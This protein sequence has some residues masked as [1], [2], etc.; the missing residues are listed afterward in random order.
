MTLSLL[1][2]PNTDFLRLLFQCIQLFSWNIQ[3]LLSIKWA[4][5]HSYTQ[6]LYFFQHLFP[7]THCFSPNTHT[8]WKFSIYVPVFKTLS[9]K[10]LKLTA[11][12]FIFIFAYMY[13]LQ[14]CT[15]LHLSNTNS[16]VFDL[17]IFWLIFLIASYN[18]SNICCKL[19]EITTFLHIKG[20]ASSSLIT[21]F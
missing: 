14:S 1:V 2:L 11:L 8:S 12:I 10:I 4:E 19:F 16:L 9:A 6:L 13:N 17:L 3:F 15:L 7:A 20:D 18:L 5:A 21:Q